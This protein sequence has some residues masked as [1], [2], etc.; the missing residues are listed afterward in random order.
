MQDMSLEELKALDVRGQV[1]PTLAEALALAKELGLGLV[2]EMKEEGLEE[3]VAEALLGSQLHG[4]FLLS[5]LLARIQ[6]TIGPTNRNH[7]LIAAYKAR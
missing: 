4:Y 7:H 5:F 6:R 2:V 1:V 3:L